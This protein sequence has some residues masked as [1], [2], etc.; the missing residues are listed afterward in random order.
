MCLL[1]LHKLLYN[2]SSQYHMLF[3]HSV[4]TEQE[5]ARPLGHSVSQSWT[6]ALVAMNSNATTLVASEDPGSYSRAIHIRKDHHKVAF[7]GKQKK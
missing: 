5:T 4:T 1:Q 6:T 2:K 7:D 3:S